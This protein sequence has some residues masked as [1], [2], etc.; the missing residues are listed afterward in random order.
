MSKDAYWFRHDST[1][2]RALKMRKMSFIYGHWGKGIYW[3][4]VEILRDQEYYEFESDEQSL[5]MLCELIGSKD[6]EKFSNWFN[7]CVKFELFED[8][9]GTFTCPPL[10]ANMVKW[11]SAKANGNKGGRPSKRSQ[12]NPTVTQPITETKPNANPT[13]NPTVTI[14]EENNTKEEKTKT[15][16]L[17][18]QKWIESVA[19][20]YKFTADQITA[21]LVSFIHEQSLKGEL[22]RPLKDLKNHFVNVIKKLPPPTFE[23]PFANYAV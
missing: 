18:S 5:R 12:N 4:V 3:D 11:D 6:W 16:L 15:D 23:S 21:H 9:Y 1:A 19:K 17:N 7:D 13:H 2:G 8:S 14:R 20:N 22:D 10:T